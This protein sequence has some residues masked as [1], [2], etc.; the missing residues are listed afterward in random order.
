MKIGVVGFQGAIEEHLK[1][2][3]RAMESKELEGRTF[4]LKDRSQ[5][6][7]VDGIIIPGGESTTIGKLMMNS[8]IFNKIREMGDE[9]LP[10]MGTCAGM[11][12]LAKEGSE[13]IGKT[14]QPLLE[15]V[16]MEVTRNAFGR[17]KESFETEIEIPVLGEKEFPCVFIRAPA[18]ERV[19]NDAKSLAKYKGKTIAVEQDNIVSFAFHPELTR[20]T[21]THEYFLK[22]VSNSSYRS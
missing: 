9:G 4:R 8:G 18:V 20:D 21:R 3:K 5:L 10:I 1:T 15:L 19:K 11:I 17:Q 6:S 2:I 14:E 22:K 16:D 13:E 12:L 7:E